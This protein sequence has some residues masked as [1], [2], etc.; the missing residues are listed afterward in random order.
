MVFGEEDELNRAG[1]QSKYSVIV[2]IFLMVN[3]QFG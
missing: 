1:N 2:V 3:F